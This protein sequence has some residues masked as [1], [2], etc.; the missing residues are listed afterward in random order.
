MALMDMEPGQN[1]RAPGIWTFGTE[2]KPDAV[3]ITSEGEI[4]MDGILHAAGVAVAGAGAAARTGRVTLVSGA[5]T[6]LTHAV[7]EHSNIFLT[8]QGLTSAG[9][10]RVASRTPGTSFVIQAVPLVGTAEVAWL[11]VEP[12]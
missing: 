4:L 9:P 3:T 6:V 7:T 11:L 12:E 5:A 10:L 2:D 1:S 8:P